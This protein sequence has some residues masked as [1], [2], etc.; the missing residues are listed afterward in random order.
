MKPVRLARQVAT[1]LAEAAAWYEAQRGGLGD[2]L[3]A[4][5]EGVLARIETRPTSGAMVPAA[6][7]PDVR[8]NR[9]DET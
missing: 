4:A 6:G 9:T 3:V 8:Q 2:E 5:V 1:E 7:D